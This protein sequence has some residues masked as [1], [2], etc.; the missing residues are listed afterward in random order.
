MEALIV[1]VIL[2]VLGMILGVT[3]D[4]VAAV[5]M[6]LMMIA[7]VFMLAFFSVMTVVLL[8]SKRAEGE[9]DG[10]DKPEHGYETAMYLCKTD[11]GSERLPNVFPA[12]NIMRGMIYKKGKAKLRLFRGKRRSFVIDRHSMAIVIFGMILTLPSLVYVAIEF[13]QMRQGN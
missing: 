11:E 10:F 8:R 1:I 3:L 4:S 5:L 9:L 2:I 13:I 6:I 12:E 7:L